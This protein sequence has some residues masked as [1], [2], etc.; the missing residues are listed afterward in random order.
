MGFAPSPNTVHV[1]RTFEVIGILGFF[2]PSALAVGL[3]CRPAFDLF[4][5]L[6][7]GSV[8]G[9]GNE[10]LL[11]FLALTPHRLWRHRLIPPKPMSTLVAERKGRR[12]RERTE[13]D[14]GRRQEE[15]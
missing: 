5:I 6:L 7:A 1:N 11:A 8:P 15:N 3:A 10:K 2:E 12:L 4:A 13:E 14:R 9:V